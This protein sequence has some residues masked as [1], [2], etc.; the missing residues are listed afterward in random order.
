MSAVL[1]VSPG[2][3]VT[4]G[5]VARRARPSHRLAA[6][7]RATSLDRAIAAGTPP[8]SSVAL[9]L[10]AHR[11]VGPHVRRQL[12]ADIGCLIGMAW[13]PSPCRSVTV[14]RCRRQLRETAHQLEE[15]AQMLRAPTPVEARGV[16]LTRLLFVEGNG[17]LYRPCGDG[18]PQR[19]HAAL[20][21]AINGLTCRR[22]RS[23]A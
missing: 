10:R 8:D 5:V 18:S 1:L 9:E 21:E 12:A 23:D 20:C 7:W 16:A 11:L 15:L 2:G 4:S 17:P 13:D 3:L 19:L 14:P 22:S 6:R